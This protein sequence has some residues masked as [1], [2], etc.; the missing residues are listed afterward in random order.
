MRVLSSCPGCRPLSKSLPAASR[1]HLPRGPWH[2]VLECLCA[3]FPAIAEEVWRSRMQRGLVQD[4]AG[5]PLNEHSPYREGLGVQYYRE[6]ADEPQ[7]PFELE[8]LY[9]DEHLLVVD[10]PHFLACAPVGQ[11]VE[12]TALI[13]LQRLLDNPQL[14]PLHRLDRLTAGLLMFS[15]QPSSRDAYQA[16]FRERRI[17][18]TYE[19][20]APALEQLQFS[21]LAE[22]CLERGEPFF[23]TRIAEGPANSQTRIEVLERRADCWL[24]A[25]YPHSGRKHQLRVQ[26]AA[27]GA[28]LLN[29]PWYPVVQA[30]EADDFSRPLQLLARRLSFADPLSGELREFVSRRQLS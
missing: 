22:H 30:E 5:Q 4:L 13:R 9:Q 21:Y 17:D 3:R 29:D 12:Q 6:V 1:L 27:L 24:Y 14:V 28:P 23:L 7:I 26:M 10:K 19:A 18:K 8:I 15:C 2:T 20:L 25:L 16:L 11:W